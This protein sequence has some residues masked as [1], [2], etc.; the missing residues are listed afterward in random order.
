MTDGDGEG[1][2]EG[3]SGSKYTIK[4]SKKPLIAMCDFSNASSADSGKVLR[5]LFAEEL[6]QMRGRDIAEAMFLAGA[7]I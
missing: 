7:T 2:G 5:D 4:Y 1:E 6:H 3:G